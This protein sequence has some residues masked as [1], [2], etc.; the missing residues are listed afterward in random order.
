MFCNVFLVT[1]LCLYVC[2]YFQIFVAGDQ[3]FH[4]MT[5]QLSSSSPNSRTNNYLFNV[6]VIALLLKLNLAKKHNPNRCLSVQYRTL[7]MVTLFEINTYRN[8][9]AA[10]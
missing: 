5:S 9:T 2:V 3:M 6:C 7:S 8:A 10:N 4:C 1:I